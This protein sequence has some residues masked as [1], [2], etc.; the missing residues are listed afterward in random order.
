MDWVAGNLY[1]TEIDR[2]GQKSKNGRVMVSKIDGRYKRSI[3]VSS[4]SVSII[5]FFNIISLYSYFSLATCREF[6]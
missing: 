6:F 1:W 5:Q 4:K 2:S 3:F